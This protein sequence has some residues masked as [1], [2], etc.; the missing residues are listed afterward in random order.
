MLGPPA[1][2]VAPALRTLLLC[3]LVLYKI[4]NKAL[5]YLLHVQLSQL[6]LSKSR[7]GTNVKP[8]GV[9]FASP[10]DAK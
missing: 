9:A 4:C 5:W 3:G 7:S 10:G 2:S 6:N 1:R 8:N